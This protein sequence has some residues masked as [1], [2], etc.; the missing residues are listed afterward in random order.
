LLLVAHLEVQDHVV[1]VDYVN[2]E[3]GLAALCLDGLPANKLM[4]LFVITEKS[5]TQSVQLV[6]DINVVALHLYL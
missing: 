5:E 4:F 2:S 1:G 3:G 6:L